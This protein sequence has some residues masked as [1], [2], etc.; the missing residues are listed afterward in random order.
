MPTDL[1][2]LKF[3]QL[4]VVGLTA[5]ALIT[6]TPWISGVLG[7]AMLFGAA[8]PQR[9]PLRAAYRALS[10]RLG[11]TPQIVD[12]APDAHHFAQ[13]VGSAFLL[14]SFAALL[15][16]FTGLGVALGFTVIGLAMLNLTTQ[17]CVGCL[18]YYRYKLLR[19]R[20]G[21]RA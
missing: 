1:A 4:S 18:L 21:A 7:A 16:G 17:I 20:L 19:Y 3:N 14:A 6:R 13:G 15:G 9:S 2:A 10:P 12:E 11:L 8:F 5:L